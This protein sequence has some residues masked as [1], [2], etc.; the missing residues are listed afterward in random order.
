MINSN[1][2]PQ[3]QMNKVLRASKIEGECIGF[4]QHRHMAFFEIKLAPGASVSKIERSVR[5]IALD[6][7]SKT[8]PIVK[9]LPEQGIVRLQVA[10]K[11][12]ET[13]PLE[14]LFDGAK[15]YP[16]VMLPFVLGET[17]EGQQLWVDLSKHP[18]TLVAGGT[19]S[20][21]SVFLHALIGNASLLNGIG[22]RDIRVFLS[23][24]KRVEF[25]RYD[26]PAMKGFVQNVAYDYEDTIAML[27]NLESAMEARYAMMA[28]YGM[29]SLADSPAMFPQFVVIIDE[30]SDLMLQD[31]RIK[32]FENLVCRLAQKC[33]AAGIY[34][35]LATQRP[36]VDVLTGVI[37]A[38]FPARISC[39]V[40]T[41]VDS[42]VIIDS[43]GAERLLGKG[44]AILQ[45]PEKD[46]VRF[47]VAYTEAKKVV[48]DF[49]LM[50]SNKK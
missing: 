25:T 23:D 22:A 48:E 28:S 14:K 40:A 37:K 7:R 18:H 8:T 44:D 46:G 16:N 27:E 19:G 36:S 9:L 26:N 1:Q 6:I 41:K 10:T 4:K 47:Q 35:V 42:I 29:T 17:D 24:P 50:T 12:P 45:S 32:L 33:R 30:V 21:K 5:E 49:K 38:N 2:T 43:P 39:R 15:L 31:K 3:Q 11:D 34:L 13:L 20:G